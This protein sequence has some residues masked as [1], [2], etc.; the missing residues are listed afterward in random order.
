M[1][2]RAPRR[3]DHSVAARAQEQQVEFLNHRGEKLV[4]TLTDPELDV[5][6]NPQNLAQTPVVILAH[7]YM[8]TRNS[9]LLVRLATA[10][11]RSCQLSS[12]RFDFSG[13]G[14]SEGAFRYGQYRYRRF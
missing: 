11:A 7:G 5:Q 4:G 12:L 1:G 8:S 10:L 6:V 2:L 3:T 13:N 9:E 14:D